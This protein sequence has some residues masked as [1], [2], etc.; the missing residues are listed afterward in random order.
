M[1]V[2]FAND[3]PPESA[4]TG[5]R[6]QFA[7]GR[8]ALIP[9]RG[10]AKSQVPSNACASSSGAQITASTS[11]NNSDNGSDMDVDGDMDGDGDTADDGC[12]LVSCK[13]FFGNDLRDT[14]ESAFCI[15]SRAG[16]PS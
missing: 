8:V 9:L 1:P 15:A 10:Q 3:P 13:L 4:Q 16:S 11:A 5:S 7:D 6:V 2:I 12:S 14:D